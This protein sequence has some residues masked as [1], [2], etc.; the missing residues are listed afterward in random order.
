[1]SDATVNRAHTQVA[2]V[3]SRSPQSGVGAL[4]VSN[5]DGSSPHALTTMPAAPSSPST[6]ASGDLSP[7]WSW[8]GTKIAFIRLTN[9]VGVAT[10]YAVW[11]MNADGSDQASLGVDASNV[12]WS[13]DGRTLAIRNGDPEEIGVVTLT[14]RQ[15]HWLT[16]SDGSIEQFTPAFSPDGRSIVYGQTFA[17]ASQPAGLFVANVDGS[18]AHRITTCDGSC[19]ED[20]SP[21]WSSDGADIAFVREIPDTQSRLVSQIYVVTPSGPSAPHA[22]TVG[23]ASHDSP[24]W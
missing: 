4:V 1:V 22:L 14:T 10:N 16:P 21:T 20:D 17:Y 18:D 12:N 8:D 6:L 19:D 3:V 24:S 2:Y 15:T 5:I 11:T 23:P 9:G 7:A 13:P